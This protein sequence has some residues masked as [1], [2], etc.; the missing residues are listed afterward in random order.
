[1]RVGDLVSVGSINSPGL[2]L[3]MHPTIGT[4]IRMIEVFWMSSLAYGLYSEKSVSLLNE[5]V[6]ENR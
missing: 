3:A 6:D 1:V 5:V 2:I 4:D